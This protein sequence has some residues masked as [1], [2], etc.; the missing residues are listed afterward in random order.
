MAQALGGMMAVTGKEEGEPTRVGVAITDLMTG[1]F[2][3]N[4]ILAAL[5]GRER[6]GEGQRIDMALLDT[7]VATLS[8]V[9]SNYLV[10]GEA[11][12]RYGNAHPN[13]VPYQS[14]KASDNYIAFAAGNDAQW[15]KFCEAIE[16]EEWLKDERFA[17]NTGRVKN[18]EELIPLLNALFATRPA[19]EW[20]DLCEKIGIPAAPINSIPEVF[21]HPQVEA[22]QRVLHAEHPTAGSIPLVASPMNIS[23]AATSIRYAPPELGEHSEEILREVLGYDGARIEVLKQNG[24]V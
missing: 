15:K 13:I 2:A 24:L 22:R 8:Y 1:I 20:I 11:P 21:A 23:P 5:F 12:K 3:C 16:G 6:T 7:Q 19:E 14:F 4:A 17:E 9:A 18:R 10:S